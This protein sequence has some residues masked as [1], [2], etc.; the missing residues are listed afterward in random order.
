M[1]KPRLFTKQERKRITNAMEFGPVCGHTK[2]STFARSTNDVSD[3]GTF[4]RSALQQADAL[5]KTAEPE[6]AAA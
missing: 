6:P 4:K 5:L 2:W 1:S 3:S